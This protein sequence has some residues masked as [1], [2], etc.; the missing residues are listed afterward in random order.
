MNKKSTTEEFIEK[1]KKIHGNT[2]GYEEFDYVTAK[3]KGKIICYIHGIFEQTPDS[4][5]RGSGCQ[6][7]GNIKIKEKQISTKEI[8]LEKTYKIHGVLYAYGI[9]KYTGN[10]KKGKIVCK[11]HTTYFEQTP[12]KHLQGQGCP[13]CGIIKSANLR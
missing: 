11:I 4:H 6:A 3:I 13:N 5:L 2:Y 10:H 9:F 12:A 7:C 1:A 8:F